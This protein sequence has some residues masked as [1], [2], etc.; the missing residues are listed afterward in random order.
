MSG[1]TWIGPDDSLSVG[2]TGF[3]VETARHGCAGS[4]SLRSVPAHTNMSHE[5]RLHG[6]CGTYNDSATHARGMARVVKLARNGRALVRGLD[7]DELRA[8]LEEFG[9]PELLP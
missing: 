9:Y 8:A 6:W 2:D 4:C 1:Q 5:P 3:L 7:G